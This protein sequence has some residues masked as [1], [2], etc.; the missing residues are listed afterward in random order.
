M[1]SKKD[2]SHSWQD[3]LRVINRCP[4]CGSVYSEQKA[5]LFAQREKTQMIHFAC[6]SCQGNFI[7]MVMFMNRGLST[8][9][10]ISDLNFEDAK[11]KFVLPPITLDEVIIYHKDIQ[12]NQIII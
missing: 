12:N 5:K 1:G 11:N 7:A 8:I 3:I 10:L 6:E 2:R 9:G 4:V